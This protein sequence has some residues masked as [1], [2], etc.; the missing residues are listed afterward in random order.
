[1]KQEVVVPKDFNTMGQQFSYF[2]GAVKIFFGAESLLRIELN[3]LLHMVGKHKKYFRDATALDEWFPCKF[4]FAV[5][6]RVQLFL[7]QCKVAENRFDVNDKLLDFSDITDSI[8]FGNFRMPLPPAFKKVTTAVIGEKRAGD[9]NQ[10]NGK[11]QKGEK[12]GKEK[13][14]E[15]LVPVKNLDQHEAFKMRE[16]ESFRKNF[17]TAHKEDRPTWDGTKSSKMCI[18]YH[19]LGQCFES[20][21]RKESHL[22]KEQLPADKVEE[23]RAFIAKCR[24]E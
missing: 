15:P 3:K 24:G 4:L 5:D 8:L 2:V 16:G 19:I 22:P 12:N 6:R 14:K 20:C 9:N 7:T 18:R 17:K 10:A 11:R 21:D 13:D 23:M 1:M